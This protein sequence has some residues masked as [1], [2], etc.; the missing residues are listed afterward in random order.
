MRAVYGNGT[1]LAQASALTRPACDDATERRRLGTIRSMPGGAAVERKRPRTLVIV[2]VVAGVVIALVTLAAVATALFVLPAR[3]EVTDADQDMVLPEEPLPETPLV[4]TSMTIEEESE[5]VAK[6]IDDTAA[7]WR[8]YVTGVEVVTWLRRPLIVVSTSIGPEQA[9]LSDELANGIQDLASILATPEGAPY[10]YYVHVLDSEGETVGSLGAT[11]ARW[12][13]DEAPS[14]PTDASALYLWLEAVYGPKS[15]A[16][17]AWFGHIIGI[18]SE[19]DDPEGYVVV[20]TDLDPNEAGDYAVAET[21]YAAVNSSGAKF[22]PGVRIYFG[23]GAYEWSGMLDGQDPY[24][25]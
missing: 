14:A 6:A 19:A 3:T 4:E 10:T 17:E 21:I 23:D 24:R 13:I 5:A 16:P 22:A 20:R 11:D 12:A 1:R 8:Q 25:M 9:A 2:L 18:A 15:S 7:S